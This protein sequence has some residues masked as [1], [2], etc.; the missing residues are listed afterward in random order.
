MILKVG[1]KVRL[2]VG[3]EL[4]L[5]VGVEAGVKVEVEVKVEARVGVAGAV[6]EAGDHPHLTSVVP[7]A[8]GQD[9][10]CQR[11]IQTVSNLIENLQ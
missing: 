11:S 4:I 2:K 9:Q 6:S 7:Q 8:P 5:E 10:L 3:I 1:V